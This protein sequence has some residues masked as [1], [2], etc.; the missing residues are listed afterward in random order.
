M[1]MIKQFSENGPVGV[2]KLCCTIAAVHIRALTALRQ[3]KPTSPRCPSAWQ[4]NPGRRSTYRRGKSAQTTGTTSVDTKKK[5]LIGEFK[6]PGSDYGPKGKPIEVDAHDFEKK[7]LGKVVPYGVYDVGANIGY[8][9]LGI[10]H[11]RLV[12]ATGNRTGRRA[13]DCEYIRNCQTTE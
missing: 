1:Q 2:L 5:E 3:I 11:D 4:P 9:S 8:V 10:G 13:S 12:L 6:N 7:E